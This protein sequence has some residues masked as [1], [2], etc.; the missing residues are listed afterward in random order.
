MG[1]ADLHYVFSVVINTIILG[2][3]HKAEFFAVFKSTIIRQV[4]Y[5]FMRITGEMA[6]FKISL[7]LYMN[8]MINIEWYDIQT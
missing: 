6:S 4:Y 8:E 2:I 7:I 5:R 3:I 1:I